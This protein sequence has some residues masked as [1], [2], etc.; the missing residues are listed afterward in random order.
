[1]ASVIC[2]SLP[3]YT[4]AFLLL[5]HNTHHSFTLFCGVA[6]LVCTA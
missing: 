6:V 3:P 1:M 5:P 2:S 4:R